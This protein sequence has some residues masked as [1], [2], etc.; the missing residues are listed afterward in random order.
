MDEEESEALTHLALLSED[1][2]PAIWAILRRE[3]FVRELS[4]RNRTHV[5][6][7]LRTDSIQVQEE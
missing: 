3:F 4:G 6:E 5:I 2:H 1:A 7:F